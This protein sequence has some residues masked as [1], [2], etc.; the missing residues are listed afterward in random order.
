MTL[1]VGTR[2]G[3]YRLDGQNADE[4]VAGSANVAHSELL[5]P[6]A[7]SDDSLHAGQAGWNPIFEGP[8]RLTAIGEGTGRLL[9]GTAAPP[10][11]FYT[12]DGEVWSELDV[13]ER[14]PLRRHLQGRGTVITG[15]AGP[16]VKH[17]SGVPDTSQGILVGLEG[18]TLLVSYDAGSAWQTC[19]RGLGADVHSIRTLTDREWL[20]ATGNGLYRTR[21]CGQTWI[22]LDTSQTYQQY[23]YYHAVLQHDGRMV[24]AG[25]ANMPGSWT[26]DGGAEGI[27]LMEEDGELV[28]EPYP[29][30]PAEYPMALA[31]LDDTL[32]AGTV[33][34]D[35][36]EPGTSP[37]RVVA[38]SGDSWTE[39]GRLPGGVTSIARLE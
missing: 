31:S 11:V 14:P 6:V 13:P 10:T 4:L 9:V 7:V 16:P 32:Y 24:A 17:V 23:T 27:I 19:D 22:R 37:G 39:I 28:H 20:A 5:G 38:W 12:A 34:Q 21:D 2:N 18:D 26:G 33:A 3:V 8:C 29:G 35:L 30:G 25:G 1:L 36:D 15:E